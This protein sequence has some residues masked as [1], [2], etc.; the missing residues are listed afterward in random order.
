MIRFLRALP[1]SG[2]CL[3]PVRPN[4]RALHLWGGRDGS[5]IV[6]AQLTRTSMIRPLLAYSP[7][8]THCSGFHTSTSSRSSHP[9]SIPSP[10]PSLSP[11]G[12]PLRVCVIGSGPSGFYT[13]ESLLTKYPSAHVTIFEKLPTP[14]GLVRFGVAPD[15]PEVK[16]VQ[17][18]FEKLMH[19]H[20]H[21]CTFV[22][23]VSIG[24]D[25]SIPDLYDLYHAVVLCYGAE[26]E[27]K[28]GVPGESLDGVYSARDFVAWLNGHP[29]Y[30]KAK[31][32]LSSETAVVIGQGNVAVDVARMF[33]RD[34]DDLHKTDMA[35]QAVDLLRDSRVRTVHIIGR[36]GAGQASFT[37]GELRELINIK[38]IECYLAD[39]RNL[40]IGD[41]TASELQAERGKKRMVDLI[42]KMPVRDPYSSSHLETTSNNKKLYFHFLRS[43]TEFYS[44]KTNDRKLGG[45]VLARNELSGPSGNQ[46]AEAVSGASPEQLPCGIVFRSIGYK[47]IAMPGVPFD[48]AKGI[49]PNEAGRVTYN[50][51]NG[52]D[53]VTRPDKEA[54]K[55][56]MY[57]SGWLKRG[58][59]GI[60]GDNKWDAEE[61]VAGLLADAN[62]GALSEPT[63]HTGDTDSDHLASLRSLLQRKGLR[64]VSFDQWKK[65]EQEEHARGKAKGKPTDKITVVEDMMALLEKGQ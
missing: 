10:S 65:I 51:E 14:F 44:D 36:R 22:G 45:V 59:S 26:G 43:P 34:V 12:I 21:R 20:P 32:D 18:K 25:V 19:D 7:P 64:T 47:G 3:V 1:T 4:I 30:R 23:N 16:L 37:T 13:M 41:A 57:V 31:F 39:A 55:R 62:S 52:K 63:H 61:T 29:N 60:I 15:H 54:I 2:R 11:S 49:V 24:H 46:R 48:Q 28:L 40:E 56:P 33:L 58:P 8:S 27:R 53:H 5:S 17:K 9:S 42:K 35:S 50:T 6:Q 38:N